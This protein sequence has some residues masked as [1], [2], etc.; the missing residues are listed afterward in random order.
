MGE[1]LESGMSQDREAVDDDME[2]TNIFVTSS[3]TSLKVFNVCF[4]D[5]SRN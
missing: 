3:G 1:L 4:L 5:S 2:S